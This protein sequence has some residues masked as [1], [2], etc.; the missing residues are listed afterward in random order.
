[1]ATTRVYCSALALTDSEITMPFARGWGHLALRFA[2][3]AL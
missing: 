2:G 1:M 3:E